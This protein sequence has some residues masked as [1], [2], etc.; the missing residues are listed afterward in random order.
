MNRIFI[1]CA[2]A[3]ALITIL[4]LVNGI[5]AAFAMHPHNPQLDQLSFPKFLDFYFESLPKLERMDAVVEL[6]ADPAHPFSSTP[7][8]RPA[9]QTDSPVSFSS[10]RVPAS[11]RTRGPMLLPPPRPAPAFTVITCDSGNRVELPLGGVWVKRTSVGAFHYVTGLP[12]VIYR[13]GSWVLD[14]R[15]PDPVHPT[16]RERLV[17]ANGRILIQGMPREVLDSYRRSSAPEHSKSLP[18]FFHVDVTA[19]TI[20]RYCAGPT[21]SLPLP[22]AGESLEGAFDR[23]V[24][25]L[26]DAATDVYEAGDHEMAPSPHAASTVLM[27]EHSQSE[28]PPELP[29]DLTDLHRCDAVMG[30]AGSWQLGSILPLT[31]GCPPRRSSLCDHTIMPGG[32][33]A[34]ASQD[35]GGVLPPSSPDY[36]F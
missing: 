36:D 13:D 19:R 14:C 20:T 24:S 25:D 26:E 6:E 8:A 5:E 9:A 3:F 22:T 17:D 2:R 28:L 33:A 12:T 30:T 4:G 15:E 16:H 23:A 31:E 32:A 18:K 1:L 11:L 27:S 21:V 29:S 10:A 7:K 35:L 34:A